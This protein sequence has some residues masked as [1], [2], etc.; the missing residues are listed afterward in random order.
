MCQS[1]YIRPGRWD[2]LVL[3]I[4]IPQPLAMASIRAP[5]V[6]FLKPSHYDLTALWNSSSD[7]D[8]QFFSPPLGFY[9][10]Q[11]FSASALFP[12]NFHYP[13]SS[14]LASLELLSYL[15]SWQA[16]EPCWFWSAACWQ[17]SSL[18]QLSSSQ[19]P[20]HFDSSGLETV[21]SHFL[22]WLLCVYQ[23]SLHCWR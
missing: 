7:Q 13:F 10:L 14:C 3:G 21:N 9:S 5:R 19:L 12:F 17:A 20:C 11:S 1:S 22:C 18:L 16:V 4:R 8:Q 23:P 15:Y 6:E 2:S